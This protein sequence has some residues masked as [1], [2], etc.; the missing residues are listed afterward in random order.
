MDEMSDNEDESI[1][2]HRE[3]K[4]QN[5]CNGLQFH[6][7]YFVGMPLNPLVASITTENV[8]KANTECSRGRM[9]LLG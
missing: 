3:D 5:L 9:W 1:S 6:R 4:E 8:G 7:A 2:H